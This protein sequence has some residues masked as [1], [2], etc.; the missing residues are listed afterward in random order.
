MG[1]LARA[2]PDTAR[3]RMGDGAQVLMI[4]REDFEHLP[5]LDRLFATA[6][7]RLGKARIVEGTH[8]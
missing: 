3:D 8:P 4:S 1:T 7:V 5:D 2:V 6:A